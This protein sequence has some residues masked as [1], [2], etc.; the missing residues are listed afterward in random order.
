MNCHQNNRTKLYTLLTLAGLVLLFL[1]LTLNTT[2]TLVSAQS[3]P[4]TG[5]ES[6]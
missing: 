2:E 5:I 1:G 6:K 4:L 3:E